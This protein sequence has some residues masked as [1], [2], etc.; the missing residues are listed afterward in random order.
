[1]ATI[2]ETHDSIS[3]LK[4]SNP[5]FGGSVFGSGPAGWTHEAD[6]RAYDTGEHERAAG[7][8]VA[9]TGLVADEWIPADD[10]G[11]LGWAGTEPFGQN[12]ASPSRS[13][14]LSKWTLPQEA[15]QANHYALAEPVPEPGSALLAGMAA[16]LLTRRPRRRTV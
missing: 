16:L 2:Q 12:P 10:S 6:G 11:A 13:G 9:V 3:S 8:E 15:S 14:A 7:D 5:D 4:S 1:M